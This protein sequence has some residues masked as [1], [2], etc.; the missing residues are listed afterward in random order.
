MSC[1]DANALAELVDGTLA[2]A[3]RGA[4]EAHLDQ[5]ARCAELLAE[6]A[7]GLAPTRAAPPG[8]TLVRDDGARWLAEHAG[9]DVAVVFGRPAA[10]E[11]ARVLALA[12]ALET[13]PVAGIVPVVAAGELDDE[14]F[15]ACAPVGAPE[16][17]TWRRALDAIAALHHA[18][19]V[20]G[21]LSPAC[22]HRE[23]VALA[24]VRD[25][26]YTAPEVLQ[27]APP[28]PASDQFS[29]CAIAWHALG[30]R[31]PFRGATPGALAVAMLSPPRPP[32]RDRT[33]DVLAR[34]LAADPARR[35]RSLDALAAALDRRPA[36]WFPW[37]IAV[38]AAAGAAAIWLAR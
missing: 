28:S 12:R 30:D 21:A 9:R 25:P 6:L 20:H 31:A 27:G 32:H 19:H 26:A 10:A 16:P 17:S 5:C 22:L 1:L 23:G 15:V 18:G 2:D 35:H 29:L 38:L 14:L 4:I 7:R 24:I 8:I 13:T 33:F 11:R 34:G 37:L 3:A 36:P